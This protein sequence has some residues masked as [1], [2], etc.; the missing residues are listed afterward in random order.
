MGEGLWV[1]LL[2]L[3]SGFL[4]RFD[5]A[6]S[7]SRDEAATV[8]A[9][10]EELRI[11]GWGVTG[12]ASGSSDVYCSWP[13]IRCDA[14][15]STVEEL[16]LSRLF[17]GG[18]LSLIS[19]LAALKKLDLAA[20]SFRGPIPPS[21][22]NLS[23]LEFLDMSMNMF[24]GS[25]PKELS[26]LRSLKALNF[27]DNLLVGEIPGELRQ[28][29]KLEEFQVSS[30]SLN[31]SIPAWLGNSSSLRVF[32]AYENE[33]GGEIPENLGNASQLRSLNLHSN[34]LEG[35]IPKNLFAA[36]KLQVLILTQNRLGGEIPDEI[37]SCQSL[38]SV[39]I[40][41]N[42]LVGAIPPTIGNASSLTYF[43]A[44]NNNLSGV[45]APE[46]AL[47]S[48]L[49]LLNLASNGFNGTIP[50]ELGSLPDLQELILYGNSFFGEIP[51]SILGSKNL[52]K[53]DVSNNRLN[54]TIPAEI[55]NGSR[56]QY[57][58]L[59]ENLIKG[60]IPHGIGNCI[61][62][63][64]LH[65][66][67]N[68]LT[69]SIP[70]EIGRLKNL[71]ISL[72][73]S[74]NHLHGGLPSELGKL[75][76][77]VSLDVSNNKLSGPIPPEFRGMMSL[78]EV[79]FSNN[80]LAGP[81]PEFVPFQKSPNSS[82]SGNVGL[83]GVPL[84][85]LCDGSNVDSHEGL[86]H[87]V[88]YKIVL[89][90]VGSGAAVFVAVSIVVL[91]FMMRERQEKVARASRAAEKDET[92]NRPT[93]VAGNIFIEN[94]KQ[95]IDLDSSVQATL[96]DSNIVSTGT[97]S[98]VYKVVMPSGLVLLVKRLKSVDRS[99]IHHQ[100][101]MIRELDRL[102]RLSHV[103]LM[104]PIGYA[105]Y[106]DVA[107]LLHCYLPN[108]TLAQ[109]LHVVSKEPEYEPD[110]PRRLSIAIG[111][112]EGLAFLHHLAV[113]HLDICSGIVF[114][115]ADFNAV[116][117][118]IEIS[119]LL[120]PSRGTASISAVA[121]SFGYIPPEYAYTMQ[122]TAPGNVYSYGVILLEILTTRLPVDEVFGEG[123]DLVKW[124]QGAPMRGE[125]PEQ[126]LDAK[127][128]TVSFTWR[129]EMLAVLR[130]ALLCTDNIPAKRPKMKKVLEMLQEVKQN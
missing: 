23:K 58:V 113:I 109:L 93:I 46:F 96:K 22:G 89:A 45:I 85:S 77:L 14:Q 49:T 65:L 102:S 6:V 48:N 29:E 32:A 81:I 114:L 86:H 1:L 126:I 52:N 12:N 39:R 25:I 57:L 66:G 78:I 36:G 50:E 27:S 63:L 72:N 54:G 129:K 115:D 26:G 35:N 124:V 59:G 38:S 127:L 91:L 71:Q 125:T 99:I 30:N 95:A 110:W 20:N 43:E 117:G 9:I 41:D 5:L 105:I 13:G 88:S 108:G 107:L 98:T 3:C 70:T 31:G 7:L 51:L 34:R 56:L 68:Y 130:V 47:C 18:N 90:V 17:L 60:E 67:S 121:G 123:T 42:N 116:V 103:N 33:L 61:K 11:P 92:N 120:D 112:A 83:C 80:L 16:H 106:E 15:N 53:L 104:T 75:D 44:D 62:L 37:G 79:N 118:E 111:V 40:G 4:S 24:S 128:S 119:K 87:R 55:C 122:V 82:F 76:K 19:Q 21:L 2:V 69:G 10:N 101:K 94:L 28:L 8:I 64:E 97:F 84:N 100:S 73:L 74:F